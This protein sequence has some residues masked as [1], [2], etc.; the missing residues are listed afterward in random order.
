MGRVKVVQCAVQCA[1]KSRFTRSLWR[2]SVRNQA[3]GENYHLWPGGH[4]PMGSRGGRN[5]S[6]RQGKDYSDIISDLGEISRS[7]CKLKVG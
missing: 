1:G 7:V 6:N 5:D 4:S 3:M 2:A